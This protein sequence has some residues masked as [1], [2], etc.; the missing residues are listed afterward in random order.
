M[1]YVAGR[2][3]AV[4]VFSEVGT[5][6]PRPALQ[7]RRAVDLIAD[8]QGYFT[9]GGQYVPVT[10]ERMIDS[11]YPHDGL[12]AF[13]TLGAGQ[14]ADNAGHR[15]RGRADHRATAVVVSV[16]A[17]TPTAGGYVPAYP[18]GGTLPTAS[19]VNFG[20]GVTHGETSSSPRS[21][22]EAGSRSTTRPAARTSSSTSW[23]T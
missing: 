6:W 4:A 18:Y 23:A 7:L 16:T 5:G 8:V 9:T 12:P 20:A 19:N 15:L 2:T 17:V 1:N 22:R 14:V 21:V 11:R 3:G 10:P 13:G